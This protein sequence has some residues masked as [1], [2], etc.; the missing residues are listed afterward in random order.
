MNQLK[1]VPSSQT[2]QKLPEEKLWYAVIVQAF[3][4]AAYAGNR[5]DPLYAKREAIEWMT[6]Q[7][8]DFKLVFHY[9]GYEYEYAVKKVRKLLSSLTYNFSSIQWDILTKKKF[10]PRV[11][12][13]IKY[14]LSF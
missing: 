6:T 4:D 12:N 11:R 9:A 10:T 1:T 8:K 7:G 14:K 3:T 5:R 13:D 2:E